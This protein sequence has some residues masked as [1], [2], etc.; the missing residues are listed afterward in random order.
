MTKDELK[1]KIVKKLMNLQENTYVIKEVTEILIE[2]RFKGYKRFLK[3]NVFISFPDYI[4]NDM[5]RES[6]DLDYKKIQGMEKNEIINY[7]F[8]GEGKKYFERWGDYQGKKPKVIKI[9]WD[10]LAKP[11]QNFLKNKMSG[12]NPNLSDSREKLI[13]TMKREP[14]LGKGQNEPIIITYN[15][16]GKIVDIPGGNH[17]TYA[18]FELNNFNPILMKAY[19]NN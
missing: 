6:G 3:D 4:I 16:E 19:T 7:F 1:E 10:D 8:N 14:N 12:E 2:D 5:F 15:Q 9:K 18:A 11:L 13:K 17:R